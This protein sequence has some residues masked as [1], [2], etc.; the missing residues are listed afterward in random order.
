MQEQLYL[1]T[2]FD[3]FDLHISN[4]Q[5]KQHCIIV[6]Y[7]ILDRIDSFQISRTL[8]VDVDTII[9]MIPV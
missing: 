3:L 2:W 5:G 8:V 1:E 9:S 6:C 4:I 7:I